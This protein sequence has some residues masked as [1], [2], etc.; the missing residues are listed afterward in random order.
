MNDNYIGYALQPT[1]HSIRHNT[2]SELEKRRTATAAE[3]LGIGS[4]SSPSATR[5]REKEREGKKRPHKNTTSSTPLAFSRSLY[6]YSFI[7]YYYIV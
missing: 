3:P 1:P 5:E 2:P 7:D 6:I 4:T